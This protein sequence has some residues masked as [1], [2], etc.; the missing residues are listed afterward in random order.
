[1]RRPLL[2]PFIGLLA[3]S[4]FLSAVTRYHRARWSALRRWLVSC[5]HFGHAHCSLFTVRCSLSEGL[6]ASATCS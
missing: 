1:M 4:S 6:R 3:V 5:W 2:L